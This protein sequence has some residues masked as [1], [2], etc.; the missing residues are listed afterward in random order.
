MCEKG[1]SVI[2]KS[3]NS[4]NEIRNL[5]ENLNIEFKTCEKELNKD[6]W[7]TYSSF[8]NTDGGIILLGVK[9]GKDNKSNI[10]IGVE[11]PD[12]IIK[13][14]VTTANNPS[15]VSE[16]LLK[17]SD[18][19]LITEK[20]K[21]VIVV[22]IAKLN[23]KKRPLYLKNNIFSAYKRISD[24]DQL[25]SKEEI[26]AMIRDSEGEPLDRKII[27]GFTQEDLDNL[28]VDKYRLKLKE[29][30]EECLYNSISDRKEFLSEI[31]VLVKNRETGKEEITLG[32]LLMFGK[33]N[34]ITQFLPHFH[35]EYIDK[36]DEN[37][38][39]WSDRVIFDTTWGANNIYNFFNVV[40]SKLE[41]N[42]KT[43]FKLKADNL[44]RDESSPFKKALREAFVNTLIHADY[45]FPAGIIITRLKDKYI[46]TNPGTLRISREDILSGK[47]HS[48]ARNRKLM[49]LFRFIKFSEQA[50]SG[51]KEILKAVNE[52]GLMMPDIEEK[53]GKIT[54]ILPDTKILSHDNLTEKEK[55]IMAYV[56]ENES[57][58]KGKVREIFEINDYQARKIL[59]TLIEKSYL[60]PIG[61]R[62]GVKYILKK[63]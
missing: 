7:D 11:N 10:I 28:T 30:N 36:S 25:C 14:I 37:D 59:N 43:P 41:A 39:R 29:V 33:T 40:M 47:A 53:N 50:G 3:I 52:L 57:I 26:K 1:G 49:E 13:E 20:E 63:I 35:L 42:V 31:G 19:L 54:F 34:S 9:E 12:K 4:F 8:A 38:E 60:I 62:R 18:I 23:F 58:Q 45:E 5:K 17:D 44:T 51:M 16:N 22:N 15:K 56:L 27:T 21:T 55:I 61:E 46:F 2:L 24:S 6:F 48:D 32:G